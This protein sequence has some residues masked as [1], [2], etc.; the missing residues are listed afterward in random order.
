MKT[1]PFGTIWLVLLLLLMPEYGA[2]QNAYYDHGSFPSPGTVGSS[3]GMRAELDLIEAGFAKLPSLSGNANKFVVVNGSA[4][5]LTVAE[6]AIPTGTSFPVSPDTNDLFFL[7][8]DSASG[9]CNLG[10]GLSRSL[11]YWD[12]TNWAPVSSNTVL[13]DTLDT[14]FDRGKIIDGAN[15]VANAV[16]IGDTTTPVCI[17]TD[18]VK[19]PWVRPCTDSNITTYILPNFTYSWYDVE[20]DAVMFT[21]DPDAASKNAMYQYG[22]NYKPLASVEVTL[23]PR[24][25]ASYSEASIVSNQP[26]DG[27]IQITDADTDAVDFRFVVTGKMVGI[28][29]ATV[30]LYGVSDHATP[31]GNI[32]LNCAMRSNRP[33]TDTYVAHSTTGEA[34]I[35]LTP[36]TQNRPVSAVTSAITI[37]GTVA[38][39]SEIEGSCE[40][41]ATSTTSAQ[42][43]DFF[44]RAKAIVQVLINSPSD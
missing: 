35:T 12:G 13:T 32:V 40:V 36:A 43:T 6:S 15:S 2:A 28:T 34:A 3:A 37:N 31:A 19:G 5:A 17:F 21:V 22:A 24:G 7:T 42:L 20:G 29:T 11:C 1:T 16:R 39:F 44:I 18:A 10:G 4:T 8:T 9:D 30:R 26:K 41:N 14:V 27:Y 33:G 25:A 38:E 23:F